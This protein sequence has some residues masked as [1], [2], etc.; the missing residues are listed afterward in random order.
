M[1]TNENLNKSNRLNAKENEIYT[2]TDE[3]GNEVQ[4]LKTRHLWDKRPSAKG[5]NLMSGKELKEIC[6]QSNHGLEAF[7]N[8]GEIYVNNKNGETIFNRNIEWEIAEEFC[9]EL[10]LKLTE[11]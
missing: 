5:I 2:I 4:V 10:G 7:Y 6:K 3:D 11:V 1:N 8:C 9:E